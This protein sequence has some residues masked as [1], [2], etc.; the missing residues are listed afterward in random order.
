MIRVRAFA[1]ED[2]DA[3]YRVFLRAVREGTAGA[4][5]HAQREAWARA[6]DSPPSWR[7]RLN[8]EITVVAERN[9]QVA[10]FMTLSRDGYL[11]LAFVLPEEMGKGVASALHD[12]ILHEALSRRMPRLTTDASHLARRFFLKQGWEELR[13]QQIELG[14]ELLTNFRMVKRLKVAQSSQ[15]S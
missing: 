4:Y 1:V 8:T 6:P 12:R 13:E 7:D 2:A 15:R 14:G 10:G 11:D 3:L 5:S 9:G